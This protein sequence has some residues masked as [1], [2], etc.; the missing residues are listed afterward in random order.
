VLGAAVVLK[1]EGGDELAKLGAFR[2]GRK[3]R[4]D[5]AD[6][7]DVAERPKRWRFV[8]RIPENT[9]GKRKAGEIAGLF[10]IASLLQELDARVDVMGDEARISFEPTAGLRF[11]EGHFPG[12]PVLAGVAQTHL[13]TRLGEEI[14]GFLPGSFQ[15][16]R[17]KFRRLIQPCEKI[18]LVLARDTAK[19]R[20]AFNFSADGEPAS[21]GVIGS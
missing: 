16:S 19:A 3:L 2:F 18:L 15:V 7:L 20:L 12:R 10:E 4:N 1:P 17:M 6:R 9:Q 13:A 14:W 11:F 21:E 5:L 8:G